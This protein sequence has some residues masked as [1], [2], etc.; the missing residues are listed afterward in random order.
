MMGDGTLGK[1]L[2]D[3]MVKPNEPFSINRNSDGKGDRVRGRYTVRDMYI[4]E[5]ERI[6]MAQAN[7]FPELDQRRIWVEL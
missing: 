7:F 3:I 6:W 1:S 4:L 2:Y 5:F